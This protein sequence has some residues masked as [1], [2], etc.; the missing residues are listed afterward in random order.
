MLRRVLRLTLLLPLMGVLLGVWA[1]AERAWAP[2]KPH[3]AVL[4]VAPVAGIGRVNG[5]LRLLGAWSLTS[6]D[7]DF[8][9]VS[10]LLAQGGGRFVALSDAGGVFRF[11]LDGKPRTGLQLDQI[12]R[13]CGLRGL[14]KFQDSEAMAADPAM[15]QVWIA[16]ERRDEICRTDAAFTATMATHRPTAMAPWPN[17][18]GAEAIV[19][20]ADGRFLVFAE[21]DT[22]STNPVTPVLLFDGDP[23]MPGTPVKR[24]AYRAPE[25]Y[26]PADAAQLPDGRILVLNRRFALPFRFSAKLVVIDPDALGRDAVLRGTI[27]A[28]FGAPALGENFEALAVEPTRQGTIL[29]I[30]ADNN[31]L[32]L[33]RTLL[34]KYRLVR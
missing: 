3:R 20:L 11:T 31:F 12:P 6:T 30:A 14:K 8:G 13:G 17:T 4:S 22:D 29:W 10:A 7:P 25:G 23:A 18:G 19:R 15:G 21:R 26:R 2:I 24:L 5:R 1:S 28:R 32:G 33:Q 34:L 9:G 16:L 27:V